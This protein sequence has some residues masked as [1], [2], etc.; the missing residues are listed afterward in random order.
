[1]FISARRRDGLRSGFILLSGGKTADGKQ[2]LGE[3]RIE[4]QIRGPGTKIF[5]FN[6]DAQLRAFNN[7]MNVMFFS[8]DTCHLLSK[9]GSKVHMVTTLVT[10]PQ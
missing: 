8:E 5:V 9:L 6:V 2:G 7:K 3:T 10:W 4:T 1:M